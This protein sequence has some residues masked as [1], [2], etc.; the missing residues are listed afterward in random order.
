MPQLILGVHSG[1]HDG[2]AAVLEDYSLKAAG[3][4]ERLTMWTRSRS[5][6][7]RAVTRKSE[8]R[9]GN[10]GFRRP[11]LGAIGRAPKAFSFLSAQLLKGSI[12]NGEDQGGKPRR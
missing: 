10:R 3:H 4:L 1:S 9:Y 7:R 11:V 6:T 8:L 12:R 5:S 2:A